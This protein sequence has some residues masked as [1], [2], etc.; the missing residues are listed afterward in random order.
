M[1]QLHQ[2][3]LCLSCGS[4]FLPKSS[5][6]DTYLRKGSQSVLFLNQE[7]EDN[8]D[9]R[10]VYDHPKY[11][12]VKQAGHIFHDSHHQLAIE[13]MCH[14]HTM[15][16]PVRWTSGGTRVLP[17][18]PNPPM[19]FL[20]TPAGK[21][22]KGP[23]VAT[24]NPP[25]ENAR[26]NFRALLNHIIGAADEST[27]RSTP[28]NLDETFAVCQGCNLI[29]T[30][31]NDMNFHLGLKGMRAVNPAPLLGPRGGMITQW[32]MEDRGVSAREAYGVWRRVRGKKGA[33]TEHPS[34]KAADALSPAV[35]YYLHM[36]L[37]YLGAGA[38]DPF[39]RIQNA[40]MQA[41]ALHTYLQLSW[42]VL[43]IA[44]LATLRELGRLYEP[45]GARSHGP[46]QHLGALD[47]Y[48]SYF[49]YKLMQFEFGEHVE[50]E[51]LDFVQWHQKYYWDALN[52]KGLFPSRRITH[53]LA[54]RV[55]TSV[56]QPSRVLVEEIC[57]GLM[58]LYTEDL[59][60]LISFV[61]NQGD[62]LP[63]EIRSY[64]LPL[65]A[66]RELRRR[67]AQQVNS[68]ISLLPTHPPP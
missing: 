22:G 7:F 1:T 36:C 26:L 55:Y 5:E 38:V 34:G 44:C 29:M 18:T 59:D 49:I 42:I 65:P 3:G 6:A 57:N 48:V 35:A 43:E 66:M 24:W 61:T 27:A 63:M 14:R 45:V 47:I 40:N 19:P 23:T 54:D 17:L 30:Q 60:S 20:K 16:Y 51:G 21:K 64:F 33:G 13:Y 46:Q 56:T 52:C 25:P 39:T 11:T 50:R 31:Q 67:S 53:L 8:H 12:A 4:P 32:S 2:C 37:P 15:D 62:D 28:I 68:F 58:R 41:P 10:R 9:I